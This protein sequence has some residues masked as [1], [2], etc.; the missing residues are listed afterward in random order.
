MLA[1]SSTTGSLVLPSFFSWSAIQPFEN[2][3]PNFAQTYDPVIEELAQNGIRAFPTVYGSPGWAADT[4]KHPPDAEHMDEFQ[5]FMRQAAARY[6]RN[7]T[8]RLTGA[9]DDGDEGVTVS[10][11]TVV[12]NNVAPTVVV[13]DQS[14]DEGEN[15]TF[16]VTLSAA[17]D[18]PVTMSYRTV[19]GTARA[20]DG[21]YVAKSGTLT[22]LPG[23]TTATVTVEVKGD[24][25]REGSETLGLELFGLS[26]NALFL[27][28][29]GLGT[30]LNDD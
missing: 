28:A 14:G 23:Q 24:N 9:L 1:P 8:F 16:T 11:A 10:T 5:E 26:S 7:G 20:S 6:G 4:A 12:V 13:A 25:R 15:V 21:D 18:Q 22:F 2:I 17:Y 30:I 3:G 27:D 19:N 29:F